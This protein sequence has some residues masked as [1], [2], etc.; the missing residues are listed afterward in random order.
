MILSF[1]IDF[2]DFGIKNVFD[3]VKSLFFTRERL[4]HLSQ[5]YLLFNINLRAS[6]TKGSQSKKIKK[7]LCS[8]HSWR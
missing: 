1:R 3:T 5:L 4:R 2:S 7:I 6:L 8:R